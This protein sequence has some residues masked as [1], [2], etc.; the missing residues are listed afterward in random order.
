MEQ[1]KQKGAGYN[2]T[3]N[4]V[5]FFAVTLLWTW[6]AGFIPV[7]LGIT[8]TPL[9][10]F[11]FYLGGGAP[12][13]VGVVLVL[14]TFQKDEKRDYF[15]R[16]FSPRRAGWIGFLFPVLFFACIAVASVLIS[17]KA[18]GLDMPGMDWLRIIVA[19]PLMLPVMLMFSLVSGPLNEE[20]GWRGYSLDRLFYRFGF[21][22]ASLLLGLLWTAWHLAWYFT[23]GQAQYQ[24]LQSSVWE[25]LLYVVFN[26]LL[27][28]VVSFVY[29]IANRSILAAAFTHM[30]SNFL[31]SQLLVPFSSGVRSVV[32]ITTSVFCVGVI[33][34]L[35]AS[36]RFKT[37]WNAEIEKIR[38]DL[39]RG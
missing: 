11:I 31:T 20:F 38:F 2:A 1:S 27:S 6:L 39:D 13:V 34:Y 17:V 22:R 10:M 3:K 19:N 8:G 37:K 4:L 36:T 14:L 33:L 7:W 32:F 12:S 29:I 23:P 28:C 5:I 16:C 9:G 30:M 18:L 25:A 26:T 24:M 15:A 21:L 35:S